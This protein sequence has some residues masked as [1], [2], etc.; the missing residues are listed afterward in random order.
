MNDEEFRQALLADPNAQSDEIKDAI[1]KDPAKQRFVD[2][3]RDFDAMLE[4]AMDIHVPEDLESKLLSQVVEKDNVTQLHTKKPEK[5]KAA[6]DSSYWQIAAAACFAFVIG[7]SINL[8]I[9]Q[10][11]DSDIMGAGAYALKHAHQGAQNVSFTDERISLERVNAQLVNY[12]VQMEQDIGDVQYASSFFCG[13]NKVNVLHVVFQGEQGNINLFVLPKEN[14]LDSWNEFSDEQ[15]KGRATR[16]S[17]ADLL[18]VGA[19]DEPMQ[20]FQSKIENS[21]RWKT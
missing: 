12:G 5:A 2:E 19:K 18:L 8:N 15:F 11:D 10:K 6:N 14:K 17:N 21:M 9:L 20:A 4:D 16:Y 13:H 7:L 3:L 1:A